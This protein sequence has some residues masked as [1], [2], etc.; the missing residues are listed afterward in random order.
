MS[1]L[2]STEFEI[3]GPIPHHPP[4]YPDSTRISARSVWEQFK[5]EQLQD[6]RR[7]Q[8]HR[9]Q[10]LVYGGMSMKYYYVTVGVRPHDGYSLYLAL[11]GGGGDSVET[12]DNSWERMKNYYLPSIHQGIYVVPRGITDTWDMHFRPESYIFYDRLIENMILF[13]G[14]NT[15]RI[16]LLGYSAGGDAVYQ[17]APRMTD[18]W[19][20]ANMSAGHPN[21]VELRNL[22]SMPIAL[23]AG[24]HDRHYD[25]NTET[26]RM[27]ASLD[28]LAANSSQRYVHKTFIHV[29]QGHRFC[30]NDP[31]AR[32]QTIFDNPQKW[33]VEG[34]R[35]TRECN[36]NAIHW[37]NEFTRNP[38]PSIV[39]WDLTTYA[40]RTGCDYWGY[41]GH[42]QQ[43]YWVDIGCNTAQTLGTDTIH[44]E[45]DRQN[46]TII[47]HQVGNYLRI[48][49]DSDMLD[50]EKSICVIVK[51]RKYELRVELSPYLQLET[52]KQRGD[53][54]YIFDA[55]IVVVR[56]GNDD[57]H[58][59]AGGR[60]ILGR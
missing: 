4:N 26:A 56:N 44:V 5:E 57:F 58:V 28:A 46:N 54:R 51:E 14:V 2:K 37:V 23:Q 49:I 48:L 35:E 42:G 45:I 19:A 38:R 18:R 8:E 15:D 24:E 21:S 13:E 50:L 53:P 11:H 9:D 41:S 7:L 10:V 1:K 36:T 29:D 20:A 34:S 32:R 17:I 39:V 47:V 30:D 52:V 25:R 55:C 3:P 12:N 16:F 22:A 60:E 33:L 59:T 43:R 31:S 27:N 40:D 6:G